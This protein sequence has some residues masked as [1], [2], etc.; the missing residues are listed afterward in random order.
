METIDRIAKIPLF[1]GL[2]KA[3]L[4]DLTSITINKSFLKGQTI[5]T[6]GDPGS[7]FYVAISGKVKIFK[8]S[9]D[10]KEQI[11]HIFGPNEPFGE[12]PVFEG[13]NF[14]AHAVA[15]EQTVCLYFPRTAFMGLV[16]NNP[17]LAVSMLAILSRRLRMFTALVDALSLKEAPARLASHLIFLSDSE[18]GAE[19]LR[20]DIPKGELAHLLGT[21]PETL[22]RIFA[23]MIKQDLIITDG[24][25]IKILDRQGLMEIAEGLR[26]L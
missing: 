20:L 18:S 13:R 16:K 25:K 22:S 2:P 14:P 7:G 17:S 23:R 6:E 11:L 12:V 4:N 15:L 19:E 5:F 9:S 3:Q 24:P 26:R 1:E 10:G 21:I 8:T